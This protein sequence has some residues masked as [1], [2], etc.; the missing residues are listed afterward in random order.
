MSQVCFVK[1]Q[2]PVHMPEQFEDGTFGRAIDFSDYQRM[3]TSI[4]AAP[5]Y[6]RKPVPEYAFDHNKMRRLLVRYME[7]R[8]FTRKEIAAGLS[9][10]DATR[11]HRAQE[12]LASTRPELIATINRLCGRYIAMKNGTFEEEEWFAAVPAEARETFRKEQLGKL[13][14]EIE[15][16]DTQLLML[17]ENFPAIVLGVIYRSYCV[18]ENSV[19]VGEALRMKPPLVRQMLHRLSKVWNRMQAEAELSSEPGR[20]RK[21]PLKHLL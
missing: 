8:A 19:A 18:G 12:K 15:G 13:A 7:S 3:S 11:L 5:T 21:T 4:K 9:G 14:V 16:I 20:L 17:Q 6:R 10:S 2:Q 1:P